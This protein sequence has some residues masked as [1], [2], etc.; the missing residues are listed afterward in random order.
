M[1][2]QERGS[3]WHPCALWPGCPLHL[4]SWPPLGAS[5]VVP[6]NYL[7]PLLSGQSF[8]SGTFWN[9]PSAFEAFIS[10]VIIFKSPSG[11]FLLKNK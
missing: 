3:E 11:L 9:V 7:L 4:P 6:G 10:Y 8:K 2:A 1:G 5:R